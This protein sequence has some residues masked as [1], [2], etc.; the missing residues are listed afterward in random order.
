MRLKSVFEYIKKY[1]FKGG[2]YRGL[3]L[4]TDDEKYNTLFLCEKDKYLSS[5]NNDQLFDELKILYSAFMGR[6]YGDVP[7]LFT[8]KINGLKYMKILI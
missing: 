8:R 1:G 7:S 4:L 5:L 3:K 6:P 2:Y